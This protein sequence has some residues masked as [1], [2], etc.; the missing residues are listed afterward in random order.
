MARCPF[1]MK[2]VALVSGGKDS[3]HAMWWCRAEGHEIV[4]LANLQPE[5]GTEL[6]SMMYQ[7]VG[8]EAIHLYA[9]AMGLPLFQL[10]TC[11]RAVT[12]ALSYEPA[13]GDEVEDLFALLSKV[14]AVHPDLQ[15][16]SSGAI[17]SDYQRLRVENVCGRLGL[18]SLSFL[19]R[20]NQAELLQEMVDS[21]LE[22][23]LLKVASFGLTPQKHLGRS[24]AEL[25]PDLTTMAA[26]H[27]LNPCG[28]GGEFESLVL[29]GP[30]FRKR[31]EAGQ[32]EVVIH[33]DDAFSPVAYLRLSQLR[34]VEKENRELRLPSPQDLAD[35][36][37]EAPDVLSA[38]L[39]A[40]AASQA[41]NS[42]EPGPRLFTL[43]AIGCEASGD[44]TKATCAALETLMTQLRARGLSVD[45]VTYMWVLV[46]DLATFA[47]VNKAYA[48]FFPA[49]HPPCRACL[50]VSDVISTLFE[51]FFLIASQR[52][53]NCTF[54]CFS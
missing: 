37:A 33:S 53:E 23:I 7:S 4:A 19:W 36:V 1:Q 34:L 48:A 47:D 45:H 20:R 49:Q 42:F 14:K 8:H 51:K 40:R 41:A 27:Q 5:G 9:E 30:L 21:G 3:C 44:V 24:L 16:V 18:V 22:A 38:A 35:L 6:D 15:A 25:A 11:G 28:E 29:D 50:Q 32:R 39:E 13:A 12:E 2:V 31:L 52:P 54:S 43:R 26:T 17:L 46:R 10:P